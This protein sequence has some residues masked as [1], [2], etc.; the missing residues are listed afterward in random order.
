MRFDWS[1]T[2]GISCHVSSSTTGIERHAIISTSKWPFITRYWRRFYANVLTRRSQLYGWWLSSSTDDFLACRC[3][4]SPVVS[5]KHA[6]SEQ[7]A[8]PTQLSC[9]P[10]ASAE[11]H[12]SCQ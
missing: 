10:D 6:S 7:H 3:F 5:Y 9:K 1:T 8:S 2:P 12:A 11:Q 4:G